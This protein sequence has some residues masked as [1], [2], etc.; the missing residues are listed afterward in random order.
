[1]LKEWIN[2]NFK[3]Q[4]IMEGVAKELGLSYAKKD[5]FGLIGYMR[6]FKLFDKGSGKKIKNILQKEKQEFE[7]VDIRVFDYYYIVSTGKSSVT[8]S[9][10]VFFLQT[11][12]L[13]LPQF[14]MTPEHFLLKIGKHFG[15][16]D[17]NFSEHPT[18]SDQYWLKGEEEDRIRKTMNEEVIHL[19]TIEKDWSLE[20]L[21][22][23][24]VLYKKNK[25]MLSEEVKDLY[26]K[27]V[28]VVDLFL[29]NPL[30]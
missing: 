29:A 19:F 11:K 23:Y 22:Y 8:Y 26:Q 10:T 5:E 27:G 25:L 13:S 16:E 15:M 9:Q 2:R 18:F 30:A 17:I 7:D 1:M 6:D 12:K 28:E 14:Y 21:N 24:L 4:E 3:R 20:G